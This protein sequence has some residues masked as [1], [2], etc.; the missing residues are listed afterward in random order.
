MGVGMSTGQQGRAGHAWEL[1]I[2]G[3][4]VFLLVEARPT[5]CICRAY[6]PPAEHLALIKHA[7]PPAHLLASASLSCYSYL[8]LFFFFTPL[9]TYTHIPWRIPLLQ[10]RRKETKRLSREP[11]RNAVED[12]LAAEQDICLDWAKAAGTGSIPS[13]G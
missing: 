9:A 4:P 12:R 8:S 13:R 11:Y 1:S 6:F 2:P 7:Y 5:S 10:T 3:D